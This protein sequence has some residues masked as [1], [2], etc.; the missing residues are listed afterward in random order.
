MAVMSVEACASYDLDGVRRSVTAVLAQLGGIARFVRP[1]MRVLLKPNL[2][3][4]LPLE[5]GV[6]T[7]PAVVQAVAEQVQEAGGTVLIG[8]SPGG[9]LSRG[10]VGWRAGGLIDVAERTGATLVPFEEVIWKRL[11]G[12]DYFLARPVFEAD[13]VINLP[14]LKTHMLTLFTGG[15]KNLFGAIPGTRKREAHCRALG[16]REFS[17]ILV[18]VLALVPTALTIMD[19]VIGQEGNGPGSTGTPRRYGCLAASPDPVALDAVLAGAMGYRVGQV[20]HLTLA[21]ERGLGVS[22]P[23]AVRVEGDAHVLDF[24]RVSKPWSRGWLRVPAWINPLLGRIV[25]VRPRVDA[26]LCVGCG[27]CAQVCPPQA[28]SP[29]TPPDFDLDACIECMCCAEVCSKGAITPH[30]SLI[31]R[32][33]GLGY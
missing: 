33:I 28:I 6:T 21:G 3:S 11:D 27:E 29:G 24:G 10:P 23:A 30:R 2:V 13:L 32:L 1:G 25:H 20:L 15:V 9:P 26:A 16:P 4:P 22:D 7:H 14:K 12:A 5:Q 18:D 8:D 31:A 19:G 17:H